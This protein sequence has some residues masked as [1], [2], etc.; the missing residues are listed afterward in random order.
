MSNEK[1]KGISLRLEPKVLKD[2]TILEVE[3]E[4]S[5]SGDN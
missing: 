4:I 3:K 5:N 2:I 1:K